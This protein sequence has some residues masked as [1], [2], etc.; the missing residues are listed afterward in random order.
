M[1]ASTG[2]GGTLGVIGTLGLRRLRFQKPAFG[3]FM[4]NASVHR[5]SPRRES[6][7]WVAAVNNDVRDNMNAKLVFKISVLSKNTGI[8]RI[9]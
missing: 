1:M 6:G 8:D 4:M 3:P 9:D 5:E 2:V 7:R